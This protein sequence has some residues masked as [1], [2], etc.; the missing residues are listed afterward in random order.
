MF[1]IVFHMKVAS[2]RVTGYRANPF[3]FSTV[4]VPSEGLSS[5]LILKVV[6]GVFFEHFYLNELALET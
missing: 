4:S 1:L 5:L 3:V 2:G 6:R